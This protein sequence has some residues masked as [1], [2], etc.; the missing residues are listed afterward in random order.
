L[1]RGETGRQVHGCKQCKHSK[2]ANDVNTWG[3]PVLFRPLTV[4]YPLFQLGPSLLTK[5]LRTQII[6]LIAKMSSSRAL[7]RL[8]RPSTVLTL[9]RPLTT[10]RALFADPKDRAHENAPPHREAQKATPLNPHMTNTTSTIAN[11]MPSVGA[12]KAPPEL[13]SKVDPNFVPKDAVPE[14]TERKSGG[15]QSGEPASGP[16]KDLGVGEMEGAKF[17]IEP[18]RREGEDANTMKARLLCPY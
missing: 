2:V 12:D 5:D 10:S 1:K 11:E 15:T 14:N 17:K 3:S 7:L 13:L 4:H 9:T 16:N 6:R 8:F 18:L